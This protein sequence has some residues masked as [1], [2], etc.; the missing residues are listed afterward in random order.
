MIKK[1]RLR[2]IIS[3][4][5]SILFVLAATIA[6]IN[7][8]NYIKT[9]R[10]T[11][12]LL[13]QAIEN[14]RRSIN[15]QMSGNNGE[16]GSFGEDGHYFKETDPD[17]D[18]PRGQY[19]VTVFGE[20]GNVWYTSFHVVSANKEDDQKMAIEVYNGTSSKGTIGNYR[21]KKAYIESTIPN[22]Y[23]M[24]MGSGAPEQN[25]TPFN[26]TY[27]AFVDTT[28]S[29]H[30]VGNY[31]VSSLII[32]SIS[33]VV[34]AALIIVSSHFIFKTSEESYH[35]QKAFV[36]N[37]SHELKTPLTIIST[38]IE[39]LE[40]DHGKNEWTDSIQ[41]Q[42][43][44]LTVMTN[45]LVTLSKLDE[46]NSKN[47]PMSMVSISEIA[48]ESVNAFTPT[49]QTRGFKFNSEI[50]PN[51]RV[52]ANKNL[53]NELFYIFMD[54][55]LKYTKE[56]G[57]I[58]FSLK[59]N[60]KGKVEIVFSN[61][62]EDDEIDVNQLFER[63]Y[64]SASVNKKEGSGIGLSIAKEIVELHKGKV[65]ASIKDNKIYFVIIF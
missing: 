53:I 3:A 39:I 21:Y 5:L 42:V 45:Q 57:E 33:Y 59:K 4:L 37:A 47:Y 50:A 10:E 2:F 62:I 9:E 24:G 36:T 12:R 51:V 61:D 19:F 52:N 48:Q 58:N 63:F 22:Q 40:M 35:K 28:E 6:A 13:D 46:N 11:N 41:D 55:S 32:A 27:V 26:A 30:S 65:S 7:V 44:R 43:K 25:G 29:T 49:Y 14:E 60:N 23:Q 15:R 16:M 20:D 34:I 64:R 31:V 1:L 38:D 54:N 8:A 18:T 17:K 56:K